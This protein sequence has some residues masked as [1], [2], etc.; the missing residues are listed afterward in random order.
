MTNQFRTK[1][2]M[3][4]M[5]IYQQCS[6]HLLCKSSLNRP[7]SEFK[8]P[9]KF[10]TKPQDTVAAEEMIHNRGLAPYSTE[11]QTAFPKDFQSQL[12]K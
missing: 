6:T 1:P 12:R 5:M 9:S 7:L 10:F 4:K 2:S 11:G 8:L 3:E